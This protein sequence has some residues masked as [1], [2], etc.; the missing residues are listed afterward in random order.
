VARRQDKPTPR[1]Q[2]NGD[3]GEPSWSVPMLASPAGGL[4]PGRLIEVHG[5]GPKRTKKVAD[6]WQEQKAI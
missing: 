4:E 6:A 1:R 5:L 2:A 3:D